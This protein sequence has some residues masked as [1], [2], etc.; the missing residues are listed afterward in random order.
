M[1]AAP[2]R[3][4]VA[5]LISGRGSNMQSLVHAAAAADYPAE[6]VGVFSNRADAGG[7]A[8]AAEHGIPT[9]VRSHRDFNTRADFDAEIEAVLEGWGA[10]IVCLAGFMRILSEGFV[11]RWRGRMLNIHPSLLP[12][13]KGLDPHGQA[14]AAGVTEHGCTVHW[15]IPALDDGP[16]ILAARVPV[17]PDDT[18]DTLAARVLVEE[19]KLYPEALARVA[20]GEAWLD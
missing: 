12:A 4:R 8:F 18:A 6:I 7:L 5:V 14:L 1:S 19:H 3:K 20:R 10:E 15:V 2:V 16:A 17:L 11:E 9:A 13:F